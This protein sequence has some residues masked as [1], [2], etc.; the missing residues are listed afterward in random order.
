M[1]DILNKQGGKYD[2]V[3]V[4]VMGEYPDDRDAGRS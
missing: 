2:G 1:L 3:V 4:V